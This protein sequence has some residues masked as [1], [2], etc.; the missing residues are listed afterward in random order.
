[1]FVCR[2]GVNQKKTNY[3]DE[4]VWEDVY[5]GFRDLEN[6]FEMV[7]HQTTVQPNRRRR[8]RKIKREKEEEVADKKQKEEGN[9]ENRWGGK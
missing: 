5:R 8:Q 7:E 6:L 2:R 1:M 9:G 3:T 4:F